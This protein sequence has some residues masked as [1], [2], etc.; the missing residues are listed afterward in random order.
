MSST[1][2]TVSAKAA[3]WARTRQLGQNS[4]AV[5]LFQMRPRRTLV[6]RQKAVDLVRQG[7]EVGEVHQ[8]DGAAAD[9]VLI[10]RADAAAG[11]PIAVT[12][13]EDSRTA[14]SSRCSG[15][16]SRD[17]LAM[18]RL[19]GR[20]RRPGPSAGHLVEEACGRTPHRCRSPQ[21]WSDQHAGG[22][23]RQLVGR[24]R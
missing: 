7:V 1:A 10:G 17:V 4:L 15:R 18:R 22:Q 23:Q 5:D 2:N 21:A 13:L 16:I 19:S 9:P 20:R 3:A 6:V 24:R 8:A 12:A 11:V 14:S